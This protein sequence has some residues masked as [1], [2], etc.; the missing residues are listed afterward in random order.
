MLT[1]TVFAW[2]GI[3]RLAVGAV[4]ERDYPVIMGVNLTVATVVIAAVI[5]VSVAVAVAIAT[6]IAVSPAVPVAIPVAIAAIIGQVT[7]QLGAVVCQAPFVVP[8]AALV[9]AVMLIA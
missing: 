6:V 2:P 5:P 1:E 3:G 7:V 4:F 8:D 9:G